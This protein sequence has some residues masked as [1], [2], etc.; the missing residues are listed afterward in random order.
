MSNLFSDNEM[1]AIIQDL[2]Q[3][4]KVMLARAFL[5]SK[6]YVFRAYSNNKYIQELTQKGI[7]IEVYEK[8][9][10]S[11]FKI[12]PLNYKLARQLKTEM[13]NIRRKKMKE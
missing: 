7:I 8:Q 3:P 10:I 5:Q 13:E 4:A 12:L 1:Q 11:S 2:S 6:D 9:G